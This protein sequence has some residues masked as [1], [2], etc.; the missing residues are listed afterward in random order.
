MAENS[1]I[2]SAAAKFI[3]VL[4][5]LASRK[6]TNSIQCLGRLVNKPISTEISYLLSLF[7]HG[8]FTHSCGVCAG[9]RVLVGWAEGRKQRRWRGTI[10][11]N[12]SKK[13]NNKKKLAAA[14]ENL[15]LQWGQRKIYK[16]PPCP[17][18]SVKHRGEEGAGLSPA[19]WGFWLYQGA[20]EL[21]TTQ[22]GPRP[23]VSVSVGW[24]G[25]QLL[26]FYQ[27]PGNADRDHTLKILVLGGQMNPGRRTNCGTRYRHF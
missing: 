11:K 12:S 20:E 9:E 27:A 22:M 2:R 18:T 24:D 5:G 23:G 10:S 4:R 19:R 25:A 17:C 3:R 1:T 15:L 13:T 6:H 14:R 21:V 8:S 26:H 16:S 7:T